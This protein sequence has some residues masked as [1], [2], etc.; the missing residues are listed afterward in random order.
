MLCNTEYIL[1]IF[2]PMVLYLFGPLT[3]INSNIRLYIYSVIRIRSSVVALLN[4]SWVLQ[5]LELFFESK[6]FKNAKM[7][8]VASFIVDLASFL[9]KL[10]VYKY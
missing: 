9:K 1:V 10:E 8:K 4:V 7:Q 3:V 5:K 2:W 6:E